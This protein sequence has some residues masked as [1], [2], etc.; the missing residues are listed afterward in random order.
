VIEKSEGVVK[1][2]MRET[3]R[4]DIQVQVKRLEEVSR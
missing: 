3:R 1:K 4:G 2:D